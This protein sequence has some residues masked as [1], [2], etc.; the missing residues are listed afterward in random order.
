MFYNLLI[1]IKVDSQILIKRHN[2]KLVT[3][4]IFY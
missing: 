2:F 1:N 4:D 3:I